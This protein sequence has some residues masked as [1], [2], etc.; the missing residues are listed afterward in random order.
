[1]Q[2]R[3]GAGGQV[4]PTVVAL[5]KGLPDRVAVPR[6]RPRAASSRTSRCPLS[7][8][9]SGFIRRSWHLNNTTGPVTTP[10]HNLTYGVD[11]P[12]PLLTAASSGWTV[13][14]DPSPGCATSE[15]SLRLNLPRGQPCP[16]HERGHCRRL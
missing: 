9:A 8:C 12:F 4:E 15:D 10:Q 6:P 3:D 5:P 14:P 11:G 1:M 13:D 7:T 16:R 2:R